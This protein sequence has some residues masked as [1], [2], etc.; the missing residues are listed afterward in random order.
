MINLV[1][2]GGCP[3]LA[4]TATSLLGSLYEY[5]SDNHSFG[6]YPADLYY[7]AL[8]CINEVKMHK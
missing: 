4:A 6:L 2:P 5:Y 3:H 1:F 7:I 8:L